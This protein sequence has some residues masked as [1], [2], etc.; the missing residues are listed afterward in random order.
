EA[1]FGSVL[2]AIAVKGKSTY[3]EPFGVA[4]RELAAG[5]T[6]PDFRSRNRTIYVARLR[7]VSI[8]V[9]ADDMLDAEGT[10]AIAVKALDGAVLKG[11]LLAF[12]PRR[13]CTI[14]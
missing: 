11:L 6:Y 3:V 8:A 13:T 14:E 1:V 9:A 12:N 2:V 7:N 5:G 10:A 4:D